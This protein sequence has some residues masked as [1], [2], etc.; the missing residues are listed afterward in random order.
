MFVE[1]PI[2]VQVPPTIDAK[3]TGISTLEKLSPDFRA[4]AIAGFIINAVTVVLFMNADKKPV[5][6]IIGSIS[7]RLPV[8]LILSNRADRASKIPDESIAEETTKIEASMIRKS[9]PNGANASF[10]SKIPVTTR[11][12]T[13]IIATISTEIFSVENAM[14]ASAS[15]ERTMAIC[16]QRFGYKVR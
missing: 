11:A 10:A 4:M 16:I 8:L 5:T 7:L 9:L 6:V 13:Q 12:I 15:K 3:A 2:N 14:I 1:V